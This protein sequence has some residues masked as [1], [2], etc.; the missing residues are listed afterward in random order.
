MYYINKYVIMFPFLI[1]CTDIIFINKHLITQE[2]SSKKMSSVNIDLKELAKC[3]TVKDIFELLRIVCEENKASE[4]NSESESSLSVNSFYLREPS[5]KFIRIRDYLKE[6]NTIEPR[7]FYERCNDLYYNQGYTR[8]EW[9]Y[10]K[11]CPRCLRIGSHRCC[12]SCKETVETCKCVFR[13]A[14][15][16][17]S[18][19]TRSGEVATWAK[20][21]F[22]SDKTDEKAFQDHLG[23]CEGTI[24]TDLKITFLK[25]TE[26]PSID[27]AI[28]TI[29][30]F[31]DLNRELCENCNRIHRK[32][33]TC[34]PERIKYFYN[35]P[36]R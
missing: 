25:V 32:T 31:I 11:I 9:K 34:K 1:S 35:C 15:A 29:P 6:N 10:N 28:I 30:K 8:F 20:C 12:A 22:F 21:S 27:N 36:Y 4:H 33:E 23:C 26:H 2:K 14:L 24:S 17:P 7:Y 19:F 5:R 18:T 3:I 13:C 16:Y